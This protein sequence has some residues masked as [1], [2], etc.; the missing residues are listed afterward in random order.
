MYKKKSTDVDAY[1]RNRARLIIT[2]KV[3]KELRALN[4]IDFGF[5]TE[6]F[7]EVITL[8]SAFNKTADEKRLKILGKYM[9]T[10]EDKIYLFC[11]VFGIEVLNNFILGSMQ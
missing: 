9:E 8:Y 4:E 5:N 1:I 7:D 6:I 11:L 2:R 3:I 10:N